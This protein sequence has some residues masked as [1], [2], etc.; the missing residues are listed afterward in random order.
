M[1]QTHYHVSNS[2]MSN[3][4]QDQ[5]FRKP[6]AKQWDCVIAKRCEEI[7]GLGGDVHVVRR[8]TNPAD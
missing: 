4:L 6:V 2:E 7:K 1:K 8:T 3:F 5:G